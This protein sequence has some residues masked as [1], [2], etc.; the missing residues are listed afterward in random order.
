MTM[1]NK[2]PETE[3]NYD[4]KNLLSR[5]NHKACHS[6]SSDM[7]KLGVKLTFNFAKTYN[8]RDAPF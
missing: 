6:I 1:K 3:Q 5:M 8:Q 2:M 7:H 4:S